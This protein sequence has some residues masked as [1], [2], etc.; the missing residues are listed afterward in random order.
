M[1]NEELE[2]WIRMVMSATEVDLTLDNAVC[3]EF[4]VDWEARASSD[5][6]CDDLDTADRLLDACDEDASE[7]NNQGLPGQIAFL[8]DRGWTTLEI[9]RYVCEE[10]LRGLA[11]DLLWASESGRCSSA[12][13]HLSNISQPREG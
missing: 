11:Q 12:N 3:D 1:T 6:D 7:I 10:W 13:P 5:D 2:A 4:E 8:V 9:K